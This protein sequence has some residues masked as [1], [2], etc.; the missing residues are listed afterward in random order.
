MSNDDSGF[1]PDKITFGIEVEVVAAG[2][3]K[4]KFPRDVIGGEKILYDVAERLTDNGFEVELMYNPNP[5]EMPSYTKWVVTE[6][7][8]IIYDREKIVGLFSQ[9]PSSKL[10]KLIHG[11]VEIVSPKFNLVRTQNWKAQISNLCKVLKDNYQLDFNRTTGLHVHVG[12]GDG[13]FQLPTLLNIA[14][15][16]V[17]FERA[18]E[19]WV[20]P[21][22]RG[23]TTRNKFVK[24]NA[25]NET[26]GYL[27]NRQAVERISRCKSVAEL[28]HVVNN[29]P[30]DEK[31]F[32][33]YFKYNFMSLTVIGTIEFR[34]HA[35]TRHAED[36]HMWVMLCTAL[37]KA[38]AAIDGETIR[39][40]ANSEVLDLED[41]SQLVGEK[42]VAYY[43]SR[44]LYELL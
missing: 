8:S 24:S 15:V 12:C 37:I 10:E 32:S 3:A 33:K 34:Q 23:V 18:I 13:K 2:F 30:H 41:L 43:R 27:T 25:G 6:D 31:G 26:L 42:F 21:E 36:I 39:E 1:N 35:G 40:M 22:H 28:Q 38:A 14:A 17:I 29:D 5:E 4:E 11:G 19:I 16:L 20:H 44:F 7:S 9:H